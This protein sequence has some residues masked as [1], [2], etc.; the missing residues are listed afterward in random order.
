MEII[1]RPI[2]IHDGELFATFMDQVDF[3]HQPDWKGCYC[4]FYHTLHNEE[5]WNKLRGAFNRKEAIH[6]ISEGLMHGYLAF[7]GDQPIGWLN[8]SHWENYPRTAEILKPH[9]DP[10]SALMICFLIDQRYRRQGVAKTL[11]AYA[12]SDLKSL[13][14]KKLFAI[15]ASTREITMDSYR[16]PIKMFEDHGFTPVE[17]GFGHSLMLKS[18]I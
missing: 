13:G 6:Q 5:A 18:L 14:Y 2:T 15:P 4:R 8:A 17:S 11:L 12:E 3:L 9:A 16:G 10:D 1:V 7:L